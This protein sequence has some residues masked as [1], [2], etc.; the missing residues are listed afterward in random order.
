MRDEGYRFYVG[1]DWGSE[2]HRVVVVDT[3]K[4]IVRERRVRH[5]GAELAAVAH[6][7]AELA[8]GAV[9]TVAVA[10]E[11]P[12]GPVVETLLGQGFHVYALNPKQLDRFRDRYTVAGAKDDRRD[13][14]V[15]ATALVTDR[16]AFRRLDP[17]DPRLVRLRELTRLEED[18][19]A[20]ERRL[21]NRLREQLYR[22]APGLLT[23]CPGADAPWLWALLDHAPTPAA[24][25]R[26][27][28]AAVTRVLAEH[29]I[30]KITADQVVA[31]LRA[32]ALAVGPGAVAAAE[33]HLA[34]LLPR[35]RLIHEQL[36]ACGARSER[37]LE[38][39]V[40]TQEHR[41]VGILRSLP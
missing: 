9:A 39:L 17:E 10:I 26:L 35:L 37:L 4:T 36:R 31:V 33:D 5:D 2:E 15:L 3:H 27:S 12:R 28:R 21:S 30:R 13:G 14:F 11:V 7:L 18:L 38:E 1:V 6:E 34:V 19:D 24:A 25:A 20:E 8:G 16:E 23:L 22:I 29:R 40:D 32:P 41:V